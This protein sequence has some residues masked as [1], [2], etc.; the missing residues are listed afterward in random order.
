MSKRKTYALLAAILLCYLFAMAV[1]YTD[2]RYAVFGVQN[3]ELNI[4]QGCQDITVTPIDAHLSATTHTFHFG[5]LK[6]NNEITFDSNI[7]LKMGFT[8]DIYTDP[9]KMSH[10]TGAV[11][12][13]GSISNYVIKGYFSNSAALE[14]NTLIFYLP[15]DIT[16]VDFSTQNENRVEE[17]MQYANASPTVHTTLGDDEGYLEVSSIDIS[18]YNGEIQCSV[19]GYLSNSNQAVLSQLGDGSIQ[20]EVDKLYKIEYHLNYFEALGF[21]KMLSAKQLTQ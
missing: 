7:P 1:L 6:Y 13:D 14:G 18:A 3:E 21:K 20:V 19:S 10:I 16:K 8:V 11:K 17:L 5:A 2:V 12:V 4:L 15:I 9:V